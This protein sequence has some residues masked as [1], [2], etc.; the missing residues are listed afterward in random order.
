[1]TKYT[2]TGPTGRVYRLYGCARRG[3]DRISTDYESFGAGG[4]GYCLACIPRRYRLKL[5]WRERRS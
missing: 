5:W 4:K 2:H 3:C 1:M